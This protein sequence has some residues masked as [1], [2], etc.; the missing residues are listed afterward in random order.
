MAGAVRIKGLREVDKA[1]RTMDKDAAKALRKALVEAA[2]PVAETAQETL[3][4]YR[5]ASVK[6]I[7]PRASVRG[8]FVTQGAKK[9]TGKRGDFGTLQQRTVLEPALEANSDKVMEGAERAID[10]LSRRNGF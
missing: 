4:R 1:F 5:G 6:T 8:A 9:V 10:A 3:S 2:R 7:R